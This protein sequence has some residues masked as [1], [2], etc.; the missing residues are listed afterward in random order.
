MFIKK[1]FMLIFCILIVGVVTASDN[2]KVK[3]VKKSVPTI[4]EDFNEEYESDSEI[5]TNEDA[6]IIRDDVSAMARKLDSYELIKNNNTSNKKNNT[7]SNK[8]DSIIDDDYTKYG[9]QTNYIQNISR[10]YNKFNDTSFYKNN[11]EYNGISDSINSYY[12]NVFH[13][14]TLKIQ[15]LQKIISK[16]IE[17]NMIG[18]VKDKQSYLSLEFLVFSE[19][20]IYDN[21]DIILQIDDKYRSNFRDK[22]SPSQTLSEDIF[23]NTSAVLLN[24]D[25]SKKLL[26][27]NKLSIKVGSYTSEIDKIELLKIK[28]MIYYFYKFEN[29]KL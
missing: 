26:M 10:E 20:A 22:S 21:V 3:V 17:V 6:I 28:E 16:P 7:T 27:S 14:S 29:Y 2:N 15:Y 9:I 5:E 11:R 25:V 12:T 24:S 23:R 8:K 13:L 1:I 18:I 19:E 4:T